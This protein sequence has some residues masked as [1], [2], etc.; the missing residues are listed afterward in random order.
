[1]LSVHKWVRGAKSCCA[2]EM[3]VFD[4]HRSGRPISVARDENQCTVDDMIR[5]NR[6]TKQRNIALKLV[7]SQESAPYNW[8]VKLQKGLGQVGPETID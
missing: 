4:K 1:M 2:E 5:E 3:R 7:I 6:P 8:N